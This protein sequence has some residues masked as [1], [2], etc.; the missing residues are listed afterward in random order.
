[1]VLHHA[2]SADL[3]LSHG[4]VLMMDAHNTVAQAVAVKDGKIMA[5]GANPQ[6]EPLAGASTEVIDL[7]GRT[8]IPGLADCHVHL[9]SDSSRAVE[10]VECRD[11]YDPGIDSVA[12]IVSRLRQWAASTPPGSSIARPLYLS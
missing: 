1:M 7:D 10:S 11:L 6:I 5:V 4:R 2:L 12:A 8:A 3:L 9:A